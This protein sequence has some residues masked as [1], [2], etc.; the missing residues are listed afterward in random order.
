MLI[1]RTFY[2][3]MRFVMQ[4]SATLHKHRHEVE[5]FE[6]LCAVLRLRGCAFKE[7]LEAEVAEAVGRERGE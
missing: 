1:E 4:Q 3:S 6:E 2:E 5:K 7:T